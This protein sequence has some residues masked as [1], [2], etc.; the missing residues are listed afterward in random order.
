MDVVKRFRTRNL[1]SPVLDVAYGEFILQV[2]RFS[3]VEMATASRRGEAI[4]REKGMD[5]ETAPANEKIGCLC[6]ALADNIVRHI[7]GWTHTPTDGGEAIAFSSEV[8]KELFAEMNDIEKAMLG[9]A[10]IAAQEEDQKKA[11]SAASQPQ[12]SSST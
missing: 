5:P 6:V 8:A 7:K 12:A 1:I 4:L 11:E 2:S 3:V 9:I 10:Y